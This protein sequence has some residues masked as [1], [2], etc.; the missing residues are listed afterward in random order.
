MLANYLHSIYSYF[1]ITYIVLT[2]INNLE[3]I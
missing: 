2:I 3:M 1:D